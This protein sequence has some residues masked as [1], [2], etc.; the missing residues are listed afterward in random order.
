M[1]VNKEDKKGVEE[2]KGNQGR[3]RERERRAFITCR[4]WFREEVKSRQNMGGNAG[5]RH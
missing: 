5:S 2:R 1:L 4:K 3:A